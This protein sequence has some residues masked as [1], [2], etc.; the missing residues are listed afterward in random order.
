[1]TNFSDRVLTWFDLH[2]RKDLPWQQAD[3]YRVWVSEI[4]LQQTQVQTVIPYY[5]RFTHCFPAVVDLAGAP[6]DEVLRLWSGLGYYAR[7]RNLHK[8]AGIIRDEYGGEMPASYDEI[9]AL[10]GIGRSTAGAILSL[11]YHKRQPIL[12]GNVKRVLARHMTIAGWPGLTAVANQLWDA[13][14]LHTPQDRVGAYTQAIMDLGATVCTRS[15]PRCGGCPVRDD[16][17]ALA[18]GT[19]DDYPGRKP[20]KSRPLKKTTM[21]LAVSGNAVFLERRPP[22][23]IWGG[24]WS[25]PEL[26]DGEVREWCE[27]TLDSRA[28]SIESW[29][30]LRHSFSHFDLDIQPVM[31]RV[32]SSSRKVADGDGTIWHQI[33]D[34]PPGGIAAPVQKLI[35]SLKTG[36]HVQKN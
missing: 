35:N 15:K 18:A 21:V 11:A 4:M 31:V 2:G 9:V 34:L 32:G 24:L 36:R 26:D 10:P 8:A 14:D 27:R 7:A 19:I 28:D 12:D 16:C 13:A 22:V 1:M 6:I 25:L 20:A 3:A 30:T 29:Q 33:D 5:E 23:G 17:R